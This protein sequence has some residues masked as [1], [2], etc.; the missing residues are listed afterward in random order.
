MK[1]STIGLIIFAFGLICIIGGAQDPQMKSQSAFFVV[2]AVLCAAGLIFF[3]ITRKRSPKNAMTAAGAEEGI[4]TEV[5]STPGE[6]LYCVWTENTTSFSI[7]SRCCACAKPAE[8]TVSISTRQIGN[9]IL[10]LEFPICRPCYKERY[11]WSNVIQPV[12]IRLNSQLKHM[13]FKFSNQDYAEMFAK[14]NKGE[15]LK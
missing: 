4:T 15:L 5:K 2:S 13:E 3:L 9:R 12:E 6:P 11:R 1:K 10:N 7:P 14:M 8:R